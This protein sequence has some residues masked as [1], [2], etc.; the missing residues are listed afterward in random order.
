MSGYKFSVLNKAFVIHK[1]LKTADSFHKEKD[2]EQ[3]RNRA[4]FRQFKA[5][6]KDR[7]PDSSR[8]CY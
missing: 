7:Y 4:L 1:G 3:E 6:L 5:E 8:R 2:L